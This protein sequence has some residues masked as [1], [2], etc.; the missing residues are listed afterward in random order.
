MNSCLLGWW[1]YDERTNM[2]LEELF[3]LGE[4]SCEMLI[5]GTLYVIDFKNLQ[6]YR[7]HD[8]TKKRR[9]KRDLKTAENKGIA[10]L[11]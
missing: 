6:Q 3:K 10:G 9:I 4:S 11:R 2:D 8:P 1:L 5:C 7:K